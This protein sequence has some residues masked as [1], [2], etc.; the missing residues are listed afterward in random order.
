MEERR[1]IG[2]THYLNMGFL[3]HAFSKRLNVLLSFQLGSPSLF[4][5]FRPFFRNENWKNGGTKVPSFSKL[6]A[7]I[8]WNE[9]KI[10]EIWRNTWVILFLDPGFLF[11]VILC[12][13]EFC[14][15]RQIVT[16]GQTLYLSFFN[17]I[18]HV[19]YPLSS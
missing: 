18:L 5:S 17:Q 8:W 13:F 4:T 14:L 1:T 3:L 7:S 2:I 9:S 11:L 19:P 12:C 6:V 10:K 15:I 16:V